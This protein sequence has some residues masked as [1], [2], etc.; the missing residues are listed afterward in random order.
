MITLT[1]FLGNTILSILLLI[2]KSASNKNQII[3]V[4]DKGFARETTINLQAQ[5]YYNVVCPDFGPEWQWRFQ[6]QIHY[7]KVFLLENSSG[8]DLLLGT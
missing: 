4:V 8:D 7:Q 1:K 6:A 3:Q 5:L 2:C